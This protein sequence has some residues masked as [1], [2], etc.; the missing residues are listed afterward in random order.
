MNQFSILKNNKKYMSNFN[1]FLK[2]EKR[3]TFYRFIEN[4]FGSSF[5]DWV[6]F[7]IFLTAT[8]VGVYNIFIYEN[9]KTTICENVIKIN[10]D[11]C[12]CSSS[13][14]YEYLI[15][16]KNK[17]VIEEVNISS[18]KY[19]E[20]EKKLSNNESYTYCY[21]YVDKFYIYLIIITIVLGI[22]AFVFLV[23]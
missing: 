2:N 5:W 9:K 22:I 16:I 21:T 8:M 6:F 14:G 15:Y 20:I 12:Q 4:M 10:K 7:W 23:R 1:E 19:Y 18:E 3:K 13:D 17:N 11:K